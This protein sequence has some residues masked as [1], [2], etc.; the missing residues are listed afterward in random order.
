MLQSQTANP[1]CAL[2]TTT[3]HA[4]SVCV[5]VTPTHTVTPLTP[6][7]ALLQLVVD[8]SSGVSS[9]QI[10]PQAQQT[11]LQR[12]AVRQL[13]PRA[14]ECWWA[15]G[16]TGWTLFE[17]LLTEGAVVQV[18]CRACITGLYWGLCW[19]CKAGCIGREHVMLC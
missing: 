7:T 4:P 12:D 19:L 2:T 6:T 9:L 13:L 11:P 14:E 17:S 16:H 5:S 18:L 3:H 15:A 10:T 8:P 1:A